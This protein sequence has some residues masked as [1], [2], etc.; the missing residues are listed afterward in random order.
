MVAGTT[1]GISTAS[2]IPQKNQRPTD[3]DNRATAI[4]SNKKIGHET[5]NSHCAE[6]DDIAKL[7][8]TGVHQHDVFE[9]DS[10]PII[11]TALTHHAA[12][13]H[14]AKKDH[15]RVDLIKNG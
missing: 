12:E 11:H 3:H 7:H 8:Q 2:D 13:S 4:A 1:E 6:A 5:A 10:A 14:K 9:I 15:E